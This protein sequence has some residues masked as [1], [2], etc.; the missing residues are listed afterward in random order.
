M[1]GL[2][3]TLAARRR[4][5]RTGSAVDAAAKGAFR[6]SIAGC[7]LLVAA[8]TA[9]WG[10]PAWTVVAGILAV[11]AVVALRELARPLPIRRVAATLDRML[12]LDERL[13][14][15]VEHGG[16][17]GGLLEADAARALAAA[18]VPP[19]RLPREARLLAGSALLIVAL[20]AIPAPDLAA[21]VDVLRGEGVEEEARTLDELAARDPELAPAV[22]LMAAGK[23]E[24]AL[25]ELE[26]QRVRLTDLML[27]GPAGSD[28][29]EAARA[30]IRALDAAARAVGAELV[31]LGRTVPAPAPASVGLKLERQR[32]EA[33]QR[34]RGARALR[35]GLRPS[36]TPVPPRYSRIVDAYT[37]RSR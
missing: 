5:L 29:T 24:A 9:G 13:A 35:E 28:R 3:S 6:A 19:R 33:E 21:D 2:A 36:R 14:T 16:A 18:P 10:V 20:A 31:R 27:D 32:F 8:K 37:R 22:R 23:L 34:P 26:R 1:T 17:M 11:A 7:A 30:S 4:R 12:R 25:E 15:A